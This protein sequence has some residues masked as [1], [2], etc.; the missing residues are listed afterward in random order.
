MKS[1]DEQKLEKLM[2][3]GNMYIHFRRKDSEE[4]EDSEETAVVDNVAV[5][6]F[7]VDIVVDVV[8]VVVVVVIISPSKQLFWQ[9]SK[10]QSPKGS[11]GSLVGQSISLVP[12][13]I[14]GDFMQN[15]KSKQLYNEPLTSGNIYL[16][17]SSNNQISEFRN[18]NI[19]NEILFILFFA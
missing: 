1:C 16:A 15:S 8:V 7:V 10:Q 19:Y 9:P 14:F 5:D 17:Q 18:P 2:E 13:R 6:N 4:T 3:I 12:G 11:C